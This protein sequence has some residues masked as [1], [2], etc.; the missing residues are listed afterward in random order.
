MTELRSGIIRHTECSWLDAGKPF[1]LWPLPLKFSYKIEQFK[2]TQSSP[3]FPSVKYRAAK[4]KKKKVVFTPLFWP[5]WVCVWGDGKGCEHELVLTSLQLLSDTQTGSH[6]HMTE[7]S[8]PCPIA[9]RASYVCCQ[10][11]YRPSHSYTQRERE[12]KRVRTKPGKKEM[13]RL[14]LWRVSAM[15]AS[16]CLYTWKRALILPLDLDLTLSNDY[17]L[18]YPFTSYLSHHTHAQFP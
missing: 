5:V 2:I 13:L 4:K 17:Q 3:V 11:K 1:T 8:A 16:L 9:Q 6:C 10:H 7:I 15:L 12:R 14:F 18:P